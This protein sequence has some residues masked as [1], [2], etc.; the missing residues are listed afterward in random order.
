MVESLPLLFFTG[1]F[2]RQLHCFLT[3]CSKCFQ[4]AVFSATVGWIACCGLS[5]QVV[6]QISVTKAD[7][8]DALN[9]GSS[10]VGGTVPA[11]SDTAVWNSTVTGPNSVSLGANLSLRGIQLTNPGGAVTIGAGSVL[12]VGTGGIDLSAATQDLTIS[13]GLTLGS[14]GQVWNVNT[15]RALTLNTGAFTRTAGSALNIQGAGT[16]GFS[17]TGLANVNGIVGPWATVGTGTST[18]YATLSAGN[19]VGF[20]TATAAAGFGWPSANNNT[21]N[22]DVAAVQGNLGVARQANTARYTGAAGTQNWGNNNTVAITLNG[23]M[24]VGT[25]TL[26]FSEAG[27]TSQGLLAIG[28]NNGNELVLSAVSADLQINIPI[29]NTGA[30]VGSLLVTG[31]GTVNVTSSGGASTFTGATTVASGTLAV[32][33]VGD[34]NTTSGISVNGNNARYLHTSTVTSTR[35]LTLNRGTVDGTGSVGAVT[36]ADNAANVIA[37]GNLTGT[38][39][40][41]LSSLA[42]SGDAT[43]NLRVGTGA[44]LVVTG[45]LSTTPANGTVTIN[46]TKTGWLLGANNLIGFGSFAG[47]VSDFTLGTVTGLGGRQNASGLTQSGNFIALNVTGDLPVW[48]GLNGSAWTTAALNDNTGPNNWATKTG[49]TATNFWAGDTP[50]FNDQYNLGGGPLNVATRIV[51]IQGADVSPGPITFNNSTGDYTLSSSTGNGIIGTAS[52]VKNG[53]SSLIITNS[54]AYTGSTTVNGGTLQLGDGGITG[55]LSPTSLISLAAGTNM[56]VNRSNTVT[57]G[58]DFSTAAI[59]GAGGFI[60][61]G[62]GTTVLTATNTFTGDLVINSGTL[63]AGTGQGVTP[64]ASNLG[65]LQPVA[66]RNIIVNNGGT[67]SLTGGNVL[68]TGSS[69]NT[70]SN[71][72][73]VVNEGGLFRT[74]LDGVAV[75]WWNK[76]G[77]TNLNGGTIR[78]GSGAN[79]TNFQGLALIGQVTVGGTAAS[80]IENFAASNA[81]SNGVHLG[82]NATPGQSITFDVADVTGSSASD[83]NVSTRLLNTSANLTASGLTKAGVGTMTLSA[84]NAYTGATLI[85]AGTLQIGNGV[86]DGSIATSSGITNNS[87]LGFNLLGAHTYANA[88]TGTGNLTKTGFGSL[89]LSGANN[90]SGN[91]TLDGGT[92]RLRGTVGAVSVGNSASNFLGNATSATLNMNSLSFAGNANLDLSL[93]SAPAI[94]ISGALS[95]TPAN[96][97]VVLNL[98]NTLWVTGNNSIISYGSFSGSVSDFTVGSINGFTGRQ[99]SNGLINTGSSIALNVLG[100]LPVWTGVNGSAWTTATTGDNA[101]P[102]NWA[103]KSASTATNFWVADTPEFNDTYNIGAG[104]VAVANRTVDIQS[105]NVFPGLVTFNNSAG[106]YTLSSSTANGIDGTAGLLKLG[107]SALN[108]TNNNTYSGLTTINAGSVV[109]SGGL[110]GT[111]ISVASGASLNVTPTGV[112][113]GAASLSTNGSVVLAGTST[114]TGVTTI[115]SGGSLQLGDGTTNGSITSATITNNGA[116]VYNTTGTQSNAHA[117]TGTGSITK[118]G[119]GTLTLS[120][121]TASSSGVTS[122]NAGRLIANTAFL[123]G[124]SSVNIASGATV[125]FTGS[126]V[127]S[128]TVTGSGAILNDTAS[129]IVF[130]GDHS[131]FSGTVTHSAA[132]NNTQFNTS[133]SASASAAYNITAGELIFAGAG[134]YTVS[135]GSLASTGGNIRGG[136]AAVGTTTLEIGSLNTNTSI[137][138]ALNS[139]T[140]KIIALNKVGNG[141]LTLNGTNAYTGATNVNAGTLS[142]AGSKTGAGA[143]TVASGATLNLGTNVADGTVAGAVQVNGTLSGRGSLTGPVTINGTHS[144]GNSP[145]LQSF[146][147]L[148]YTGSSVFSWELASNSSVGRGTVF[149]AVDGVGAAPRALTL[150]GAPTSNLSFNFVGSTVNWNDPFWSTNQSWSVFENF[151]DITGTPFA[152]GSVSADSNN[153]AFGSAFTAG[154]SFNW[155]VSGSSLLLNYTAVAVPEPS[156]IAMLGL[157]GICAIARHRHLR[158]KKAV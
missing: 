136:N 132:T 86:T 144:V 2:M 69:T 41:T 131:G 139:G 126:A 19:I 36:V 91:T 150:V 37:N 141:T 125:T 31:P 121:A 72:T 134:D 35:N 61:A 102:N 9:Q 110:S 34:I 83:L 87:N 100:D 28:T 94:A 143:V 59:S 14:G 98:S 18:R 65:A 49:Q 114:Y 63:A 29:A 123:N 93:N 44:G 122:V 157:L 156:T 106:D 64:T 4:A 95:T 13:S 149:D 129:T 101:G 147:N 75:G 97:T 45:A 90:Y 8:Q 76:I 74:G 99:I 55:S 96:G 78:V 67:L 38:G 68:G 6:G 142:I 148:T 81:L 20:T 56:R 154:G 58:T 153:L 16:V 10:W 84:T 66:N 138:G 7:N 73:L 80:T 51:D 146:N 155:S 82:Q 21:F 26:I 111:A 40:L 1:L 116:L 46:A 158:A 30:N 5:S 60:Q 52:L 39:A 85:N 57:Q 108:I 92:L 109:L 25:G 12:T 112:I 107:T 54:N 53:S 23:L 119:S 79:E 130:T 124:A 11:A 128:S 22:Y 152:I 137:A 140:A 118:N 135:M 27:G 50:E 133:L 42:F 117:V 115:G 3:R 24:N 103:T 32:T 105:A 127:S 88:I 77:A 104:N 89:T 17:M 62:S 71:T 48:T 70:L 113:S 151:T 43:A 15:G 33:G 120:T 47:S 145:G